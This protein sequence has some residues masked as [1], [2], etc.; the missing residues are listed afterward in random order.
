[1][2]NVQIENGYT[3]IANELLEVIYRTGFTLTELKMLLLIMR[4]SYGFSKKSHELSITFISN[5]IGVSK[6]YVAA[7]LKELID[8]NVVIVYREH[9]KN[10]SRVLGINKDY[11]EWKYSSSGS[12]VPQEVENHSGVE[13][14]FHSGVEV[15]FH[16]DKQNLKQLKQ[17]VQ[18]GEIINYLNEKAETHY[19]ENT[20]ATQRLIDARLSEGFTK[21][22]FKAVIDNK[23]NDWLN[24]KEFRQYLRPQTLFGTKFESYL[25]QRI[26]PNNKTITYES[27]TLDD[28][29]IPK[30][31]E[32]IFD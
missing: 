32:N 18:Y 7:S 19:R 27:H 5:G 20:K 1:M 4:Y 3:P 12:T 29:D 21:D 11:D 23:C 2:A 30:P 31:K 13:A 16:Q 22:D 15:Q 14:E 24:N 8:K 26:E 10:K 17:K 25:N 9:S 6:R 28:Y